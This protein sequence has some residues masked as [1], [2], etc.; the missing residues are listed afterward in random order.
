VEHQVR[1]GAVQECQR[2]AQDGEYEWRPNT[3][4]YFINGKA[5]RAANAFTPPQTS[6]QIADCGQCK[7]R[8]SHLQ[9]M[10]A[11]TAKLGFQKAPRLIA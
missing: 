10:D 7:T 6:G 3:N 4:G 9:T 11:R 5:M 1:H 8:L 2:D